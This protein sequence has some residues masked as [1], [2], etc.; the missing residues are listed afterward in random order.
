MSALSLRLPDSLHLKIRELAERDAVSINQFIATAVAEKTA[1][2]LA[3]EYLEARGR[4]GNRRL[5][6]RVLARVP[7]VPA[8]SGDERPLRQPNKSLQPTSRARKAVGK[9]TSGR[10]ARG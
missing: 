3:V 2:L 9:S 6:D 1:V 8:I 4:Q 10:A 7:D 5:F